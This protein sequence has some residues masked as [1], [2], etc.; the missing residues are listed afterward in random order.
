MFSEKVLQAL[1]YDLDPSRIKTR[2]KG[3][4]SLSYL[5]GHDIIDTANKIFGYGHWSY[6]VSTLEHVSQE[7]NE[8]QNIVVGYKAIVSLTI[9]DHLHTKHVCRE[10]VG[11]GTG[12]AKSLAEAHEGGA[13]EAVT[14][15]LKR[16]FRS[17]GNQLGNSLYGGKNRNHSNQPPAQLEQPQQHQVQNNTPT[18]YASLYKIGLSVIE[19]GNNL[20]VTGDDIFSKK[21]SIKSFGFRWDSRLKQWFKPIEQRQAA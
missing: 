11:F 10:D 18:D 12:I 17:F 5:E 1:S 13:K 15:A 7:T 3:N 16:C 6:S 4:V 8:K 14:D 21:D 20:I 9:Y 19:Q 2:E